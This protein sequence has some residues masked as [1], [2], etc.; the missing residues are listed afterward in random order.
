MKINS[1]EYVASA[2]QTADSPWEGLP[3]LAVAGRSNVGKSSLINALLKRRQMARVSGTPG[4]TRCLNFFRI[5]GRFFLVDLPGYGYAK[6]PREEQQH[7][8]K[9][10]REYLEDPRRRKVV[11]MILD[12]RREVSPLDLALKEWLDHYGTDYLVVATKADKVSGNERARQ[13]RSIR[14]RFPGREILPFSALTE[15]GR[16]DLLGCVQRKIELMEND[17]GGHDE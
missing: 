7:W 9:M 2:R 12:I 14:E 13:L 3:E 11:M 17:L 10:V 6:A 5:N 4:K 15:H 16:L 1:V 8:E